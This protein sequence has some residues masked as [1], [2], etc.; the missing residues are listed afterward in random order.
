MSPTKYPRR[1]A[2][3]PYGLL[4]L[5]WLV[6][7]SYLTHTAWFLCDDAFISFRYA[8]NLPEG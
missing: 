6:L 2:R 8:R 1:P 7:L 5:P 4:S 3:I